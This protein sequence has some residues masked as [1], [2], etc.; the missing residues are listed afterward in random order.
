MLCLALLTREILDEAEKFIQC[1]D[2]LKSEYERAKKALLDGE[3]L[4][5]VVF[6]GLKSIEKFF[7]EFASLNEISPLLT[8]PEDNYNR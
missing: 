2:Y 3:K 7:N 5:K 8:Y 6:S 1:K 4:P